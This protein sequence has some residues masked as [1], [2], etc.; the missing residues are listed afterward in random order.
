VGTL[1]DSVQEVI[2][3][4]DSQIEPA[5]QIGT[6]INTEFIRGIGKQDERFIIILDIDRIF[7]EEELTTVVE[8]VGAQ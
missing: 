6:R 4:D 5:P 7:S 8:E 2:N 3:L 1:A